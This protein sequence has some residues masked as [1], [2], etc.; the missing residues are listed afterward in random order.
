LG[1]FV[2]PL[3]GGGGGGGGAGAPRAPADA[4]ASERV[5][6]VYGINYVRFAQAV[7]VCVVLCSVVLCSL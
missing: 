5:R 6:D 7:T 1:G 3:L 4:G 2:V